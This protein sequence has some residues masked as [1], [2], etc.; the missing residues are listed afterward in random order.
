MDTSIFKYGELPE[1][2][3]FTPENISKQFPAVLE[4][5]AQDFKNIEE[6]LSNYSIQNHL[7]VASRTLLLKSVDSF[8]SFSEMLLNSS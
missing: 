4:K 2:K 7:L 5:I 3:K 6:N 8:P 1:F